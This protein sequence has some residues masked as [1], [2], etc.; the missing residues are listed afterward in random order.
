MNGG[1]W[2]VG[3]GC[4]AGVLRCVGVRCPGV[5]APGCMNTPCPGGGPLGIG[6]GVCCPYLGV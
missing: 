3:I 5:I 2:C 1:G 4:G 6:T